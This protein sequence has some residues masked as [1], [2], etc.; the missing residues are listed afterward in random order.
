MPDEHDKEYWREK[1]APKKHSKTY[2]KRKYKPKC[3]SQEYY[4]RK[5]VFGQDVKTP[6]EEIRQKRKKKPEPD[7]A[8]FWNYLDEPGK[9]MIMIL[10]VVYVCYKLSLCF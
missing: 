1:Y 5:Y 6:M 10:V 7:R 3:H 2:L 4:V 8:D 9:I